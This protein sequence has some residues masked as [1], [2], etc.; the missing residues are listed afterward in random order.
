VNFFAEAYDD[1][2][3]LLIKGE[4]MLKS[5]FVLYVCLMSSLG[6]ARD[7]R[8]HICPPMSKNPNCY[9]SSI[10]YHRPR[11]CGS[12]IR[13]VK[14]ASIRVDSRGGYHCKG[15][16]HFEF[17]CSDFVKNRGQ[18]II[19]LSADVLI[20]YVDNCHIL[21]G[22]GGRACWPAYG[23]ATDGMQCRR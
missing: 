8:Q 9:E 13:C 19:G 23:I 2:Q 20:E 11:L 21:G 4:V 17:S 12:Q 7:L 1:N 10:E 5:I 15:F 16:D 3:C 6:V 14:I 22:C 18:N